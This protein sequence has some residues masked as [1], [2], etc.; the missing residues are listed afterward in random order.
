MCSDPSIIVLGETVVRLLTDLEIII[1]QYLHGSSISFCLL[2]NT[3]NHISIKSLRLDYLQ[4]VNQGRFCGIR[5]YR[6][7]SRL[8]LVP[9]D[10]LVQNANNVFEAYCLCSLFV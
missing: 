7:G 5:P 9:T 1:K 3:L 10:F 8:Y 2:Y 4:K 6:K